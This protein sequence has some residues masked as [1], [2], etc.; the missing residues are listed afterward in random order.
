MEILKNPNFDFLGKARVFIALS[1]LVL[2]AGGLLIS[3]Q[4]LRYGVEF[5]GG[6]QLIVKFQNPPQ[7]DEIR[8]AVE[9]D[10]PGAVIQTYDDPAKNQVL[11]RLSGELKGE[12]EN[13]D[14]NRLVVA[15][16]LPAEQIVVLRAYAR[17]M[18]QIGF[19][20]S[21]AFVESTLVTHAGIA[22]SLGVSVSPL[23][24][25]PL[26]LSAALAW[27]PFVISGGLKIVYDLALYRSFISLR[28][29]DE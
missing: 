15:A 9:R 4:G 6:T 23:L 29:G 18:R 17:Y 1:L 3:R 5:Q 2:V 27:L 28:E 21:Q 14:F 8:S 16:R 25:G 24:A 10:A 22:R 12:V 7:V 11:I 20:L 13:D 19:A 26:Y